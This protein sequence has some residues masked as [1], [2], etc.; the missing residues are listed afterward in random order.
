[1]MEGHQTNKRGRFEGKTAI[2]TGAGSGIGKAAAVKLAAEGAKVALFDLL[3]ERTGQAEREIN[4]LHAGAARA[5]DVDVADPRVWRRRSAR[6]PGILGAS[7]S[8]SQTPAL[9]GDWPRW[10]ILALKN[11]KKR[12]AST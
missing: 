9:T 7:I 4:G 10:R 8:S 1:M 6:R 3:D 11:G 5:F 12:S 2:V